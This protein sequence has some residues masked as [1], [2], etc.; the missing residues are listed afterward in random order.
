M[1]PAK[2]ASTITA[3]VLLW[4]VMLISYSHAIVITPPAGAAGAAGATGPAGPAPTGGT[5]Q[6]VGYSAANTVEAQTIGGDLGSCTRSGAG[7]LQCR[8][9]QVTDT[10]PNSATGTTLNKLAILTSAG[11]A[12]IAGLGA[13]QGVLGICIA[14]CSTSGSATIQLVGPASCVFTGSFTAGDYAQV[15]ATTTGNCLDGG[16]A[17]PTSGGEFLGQIKASGSGTGVVNLI[18]PDASSAGSASISSPTELG[19]ETFYAAN[20]QHSNPVPHV[21]HG[22]LLSTGL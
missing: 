19:D 15:D 21:I 20:S 4:L 22:G 16:A 1:T 5:G 10:Y 3:F 7:T 6:I 14:N 2:K 9:N 17:I 12:Q 18:G 13:T 11:T 8:V